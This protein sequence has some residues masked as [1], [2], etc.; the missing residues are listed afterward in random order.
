[1]MQRRVDCWYD[2]KNPPK[3]DWNKSVVKEKELVLTVG[4]DKVLV[5]QKYH[6]AQKKRWVSIQGF[7]VEETPKGVYGLSR[8]YT[9][10]EKQKIEEAVNKESL[11]GKVVWSDKISLEHAVLCVRLQR[12]TEQDAKSNLEAKAV[13]NLD[14]NVLNE[15]SF[16]LKVAKYDPSEYYIVS[17]H[18]D[19]DGSGRVKKGDYITTQAY[20]VLTRGYGKN[21]V[22]QLKKVF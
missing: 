15:K 19:L 3:K 17:A 8:V 12:A 5:S 14:K 4:L 7:V 1:M 9:L 10:E 2:S 20:P 21:V 11:E 13:F 16:K 6:F 18:L 22:L